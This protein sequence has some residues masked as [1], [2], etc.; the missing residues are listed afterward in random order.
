MSRLTATNVGI[1]PLESLEFSICTIVSDRSQYA[2][3]QASYEEKGFVDGCEYLYVDNTKENVMDAFSAVNLFLSRSRGK[4]VIITHQDTRLT[5]DGRQVLESR[6]RALESIDPSWGAAGN[7]CGFGFGNHALR[8]TDPYGTDRKLGSFPQAATALD[9]NFIVLRK[10]ASLGVSHDLS[11]FHL[12][13]ADLCIHAHLRGLTCYAID[14]HLTHLSA[15]R[16]SADFYDLRNALFTK[17]SR[18]FRGWFVTT[19]STRFVLAPL[20]TLSLRLLNHLKVLSLIV[21]LQ[22]L[23]RK[24]VLF[25]RSTQ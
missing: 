10:D 2:L 17:Y 25:W 11:G 8:I 13:G 19:N 9:E 16:K 15:G 18:L 7:A 24:F 21:R 3:M 5:H 12:Y 4:S 20:P 14:F 23:A 1:G 22:R 6:L